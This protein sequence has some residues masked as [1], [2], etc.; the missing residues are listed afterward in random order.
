[1]SDRDAL[2]KSLKSKYKIPYDK[3]SM[4][5]IGRSQPKSSSLGNK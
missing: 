2:I 3:A 5:I 4:E 1:M